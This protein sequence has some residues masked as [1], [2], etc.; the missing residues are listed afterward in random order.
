MLYR[1]H[2]ALVGARTQRAADHALKQQ[3]LE[4]Y[5]TGPT[6][7]AGGLSWQSGGCALADLRGLSSSA[8]GSILFFLHGGGP[9]SEPPH[10]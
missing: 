1:C 3:Q 2:T 4:C 8:S 5:I 9:V 10:L 6:K 7:E